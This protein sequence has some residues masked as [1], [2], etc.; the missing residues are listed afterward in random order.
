MS[1]KRF[2]EKLNYCLDQTEAPNQVRERAVILSKL[3]DI[4]K[5]QAWGLIEGQ[6]LPDTSL[7]QKIASEFEVDIKWLSKD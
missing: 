5:H 2:A 1:A 6:Q 4:P 7:L 3:L